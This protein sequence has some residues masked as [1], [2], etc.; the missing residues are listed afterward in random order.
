M[1]NRVNTTKHKATTLSVLCTLVG[2]VIV[3]LLSIAYIISLAV[4]MKSDVMQLTKHITIIEFICASIFVVMSIVGIISVIDC[5]SAS[6]RYF[7]G[8]ALHWMF[9]IILSWV[10]IFLLIG[11]FGQQLSDALSEQQKDKSLVSYYGTMVG[12]SCGAFLVFCL[13]LCVCGIGR[14]MVTSSNSQSTKYRPLSD[15]DGVY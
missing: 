14:I 2:S 12:V 7:I 11:F 15:T 6:P 5:C 3:L 13:P 1:R 10:G 9:W 8:C 4:F